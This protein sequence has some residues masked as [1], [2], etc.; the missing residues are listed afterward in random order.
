MGYAFELVIQAMADAQT[1]RA[2]Q[3]QPTIFVG[4]KRLLRSKSSKPG[5]FVREVCLGFKT[6]RSAREGNYIDKKCPWTGNVSI[7]GRILRGTV[8][9]TKMERTVVLRRDYLHYITK[10]NRFEKRHRNL[11]AHCSPALKLSHGDLVIVGQCR[12]LSK[13]VRFNVLDIVSSI[14]GKKKFDQ[15]LS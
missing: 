3:K 5:R 9:S 14:G 7:R 4:A 10:Y 13:T 15:F 11:P 6:P 12:P 8:V 2:F 1:Q